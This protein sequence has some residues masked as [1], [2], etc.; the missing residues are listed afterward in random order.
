MTTFMVHSARKLHSVQSQHDYISSS[1]LRKENL[2]VSPH[3]I[4][5]HKLLSCRLATVM[6]KLYLSFPMKVL[7]LSTRQVCVV[8]WDPSQTIH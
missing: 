5:Y 7:F 4:L 3:L 6:Q 8:M 2:D 1:N